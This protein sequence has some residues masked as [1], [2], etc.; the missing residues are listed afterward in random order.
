MS[1][2]SGPGA[3]G[4]PSGAV[5]LAVEYLRGPQSSSLAPGEF[6]TQVA[7]SL[8]LA[9]VL[10]PRLTSTRVEDWLA[11]RQIPVE[12]DH[13]DGRV[14]AALV[15]YGGAG[16]AFIDGSD[17]AVERRFSLAH[18]VAHFVA[19][20]LAERARVDRIGGPGMLEVQDG[21]RRATPGERLRFAI[22][23]RPLPVRFWRCTGQAGRSEQLADRVAVELL[24]PAEALFAAAG[25]PPAHD[26]WITLR[27]RSHEAADQFEVPGRYVERQ[28]DALWRA[29]GGGPGFGDVRDGQ[30][31]VVALR[32]PSRKRVT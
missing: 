26:Y 18:E 24:A 5:Q 12:I 32:H 2:G 25:E 6:E 3:W 14:R 15:A 21:A 13:D 19:E 10:V 7:L 9:V 28:I 23:G 20:Y 27:E 29:A 31:L 11:S 16:V 22:A 30:D 1:S 8:P 4:W 17:Q